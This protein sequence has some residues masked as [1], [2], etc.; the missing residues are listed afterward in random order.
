MRGDPISLVSLK[1]TAAPASVPAQNR[2]Q[3]SWC[4]GTSRYTDPHVTRSVKP[5][6]SKEAPRGGCARIP[7]KLNA[8]G[9]VHAGVIARPICI[10]RESSPKLVAM[11][12]FTR[13]E[14]TDAV[15][16]NSVNINPQ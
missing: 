9:H 14:Q 12:S 15:G 11:T 7:G 2:W 1:L 8:A 5:A 3:E 4:V 10:P 6:K 16:G 13:E